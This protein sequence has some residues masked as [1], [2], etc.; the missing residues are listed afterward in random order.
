[1]FLGLNPDVARTRK[2]S[3]MVTV[4]LPSSSAP[5]ERPVD[6]LPTESMCAPTMTGII[7]IISDLGWGLQVPRLVLVPGILTMIDGMLNECVNLVTV[8][9]EFTAAMLERRVNNQVDA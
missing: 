2:A 4:P 7:S 6:V 9:A 8:I 3:R 1:M 5:G